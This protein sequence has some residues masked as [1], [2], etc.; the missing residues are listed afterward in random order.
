M[1]GLTE[2]EAQKLLE[3]EG[4]NVLAQGKQNSAMKI[5]IGHF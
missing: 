2:H 3:T 5:F 1:F 4:E